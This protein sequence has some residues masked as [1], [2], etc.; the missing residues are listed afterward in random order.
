VSEAPPP[1]PRPAVE[2]APNPPEMPAVDVDKLS[3][4]PTLFVDS[5]RLRHTLG[6]QRWAGFEQRACFTVCRLSDMAG[7][8]VVERFP[9]TPQGWADAWS[10]LL[11]RDAASAQAMLAILAH[12]AAGGSDVVL[13]PPP[14]PRFPSSAETRRNILTEIAKGNEKYARPFDRG[15]IALA[16]FIGTESWSDYGNVVL[17]MV[18]LDTLLSIEEKLQD[19]LQ[20]PDDEP[21]S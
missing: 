13:A 5:G 21:P 16:S 18:I 11:S 3:R 19:L 4:Y 12:R 9:L 14:P 1:R 20:I 6:W 15:K 7:I 2:G 17:Q 10:G 8:K